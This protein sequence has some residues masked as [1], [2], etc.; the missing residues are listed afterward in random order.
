MAQIIS[1]SSQY[2]GVGKSTTAVNLAASLAIAEKKVLLVDLDSKSDATRYLGYLRGDYRANL[3]NVVLGENE[4]KDVLLPTD[5]ANLTLLPSS[6]D[7]L[8]VELKCTENIELLNCLLKKFYEAK[9]FFDFIIFDCTAPQNIMTLNILKITDTILIPF[10]CE[11]SSCLNQINVIKTIDIIA[12]NYKLCYLKKVLF[13]NEFRVKEKNS[14]FLIDEMSMLY[15]KDFFKKPIPKSRKISAAA[16]Q[17]S[18]I[19][20][21]DIA[22]SGAV[23]YMNLAACLLG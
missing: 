21:Y 22:C 4:I 2:Q 23:A 18:P 9:I 8:E 10:K 17:G 19:V 6:I 13:L 1:V 7:L 15:G 3:S 14:I 11:I 16:A 12:E 20:L 5:L